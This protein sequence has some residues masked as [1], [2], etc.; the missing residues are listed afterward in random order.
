MRQFK[1]MIDNIIHNAAE[2]NIIPKEELEILLGTKDDTKPIRVGT[3]DDTKPIRESAHIVEKSDLARLVLMYT[4]G[5]FYLDVDRLVN[6]RIEDVIQPNTRLCLPTSNDANFCQ[7]LMC[8]APKNEL[9][10]SIIRDAT[11][12]RLPLKR[13]K[14]W[15]KGGAL[16][17]M[18]RYAQCDVF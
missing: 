11:N 15:C 5:G 4:E 17:E 13:R 16:F 3:K 6:K 1:A 2:S 7:D 14:G 10:L 8:T 18:V 12:M 9:F